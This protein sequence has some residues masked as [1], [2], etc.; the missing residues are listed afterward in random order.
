MLVAHWVGLPHCIVSQDNQQHGIRKHPRLCMS[1]TGAL[2]LNKQTQSL[3]HELLGLGVQGLAL[4]TLA[5]DGYKTLE[6]QGLACTFDGV[7]PSLQAILDEG[8]LCPVGCGA[9]DNLAILV[10]LQVTLDKTSS[11]LGLRA[12]EHAA[13]GTTATS[14]VALALARLH[15]LHESHC[16]KS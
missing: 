13:L 9:R 2:G 15:D 4:R 3:L 7:R 14:N 5:L 6:T 12:L 8:L 16:G 1:H 11:R 10:L